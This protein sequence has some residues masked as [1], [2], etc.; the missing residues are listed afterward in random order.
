MF[1]TITT[2]LVPPRAEC[3]TKTSRYVCAPRPA[4]FQLHHRCPQRRPCTPA[5]P[6]HLCSAIAQSQVELAVGRK[7]EASAPEYSRLTSTCD[8]TSNE[9]AVRIAVQHLT[10]PLDLATEIATLKAAFPGSVLAVVEGLG[11]R[12]IVLSIPTRASSSTSYL[13]T[14]NISSSPSWEPA[15]RNTPSKP[16]RQSPELYSAANNSTINNAARGK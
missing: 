7:L 2:P 15:A 8:Y 9:T 10:E 13:A 3:L 11:T 1:R 6:P 16:P 4:A 12:A 5:T 14:G